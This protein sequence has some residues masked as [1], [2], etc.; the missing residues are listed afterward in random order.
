MRT[1]DGPDH[2]SAPP[3]VRVEAIAITVAPAA[4]LL[5]RRLAR[6]KVRHAARVIA[7][8]AFALVALGTPIA[9]ALLSSSASRTGSAGLVQVPAAEKAAIAAA[10]GYPYPLR[11]LTVTVSTG[12]PDYAR[13][14]IDRTKGCGRYR[15]YINAS[16]HR[17]AGVW[18]LVLDE[19]QLYVPNSLL[20]PPEAGLCELPVLSVRKSLVRARP[21]SSWRERAPVRATA[22]PG[23]TRCPG[24]P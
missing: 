11:C 16:F 14:F 20:T 18:R 24:A 2:S 21:S 7:C 5:R 3:D 10:F 19:G 23:R 6:V 8:V 9:T 1:K 4:H 22:S 13:A 12:D 17:V 15:G